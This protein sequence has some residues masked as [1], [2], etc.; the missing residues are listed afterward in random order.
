MRGHQ[1][2]LAIQHTVGIEIHLVGEHTDQDHPDGEQAGKSD[3]DGRVLFDPRFL[4]NQLNEQ[5][6]HDTRHQRTNEHQR[7]IAQIVTLAARARATTSQTAGEKRDRQSRQYAMTD[8][9][10]HQRH[11]PQDQVH[12][13]QAAG[14][15]HE[16]A[17]QHHPEKHAPVQGPRLNEHALKI[18]CR[19]EFGHVF[20][21]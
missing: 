19:D 14:R 1:T 10:A 15:R 17:H 13:R 5:R 16:E 12:S 7:W 11:A 4:V 8:R 6:G 2:H 20:L 9:V 3:A 21:P 18:K